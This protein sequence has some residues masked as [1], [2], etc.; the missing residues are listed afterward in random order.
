MYVGIYSNLLVKLFLNLLTG[1]TLNQMA[2]IVA[3]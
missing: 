3:Q 1:S 2:S